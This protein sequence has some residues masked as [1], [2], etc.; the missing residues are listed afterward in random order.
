MGTCE[1]VK[2]VSKEHETGY[3]TINKSD[4]DEKVHKIYGAQ[5]TNDTE[6]TVDQIKEKLTELKIDFPANVKKDELVKLLEAANK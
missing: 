5:K 4:F 2:V 3:K 1:T 6:L